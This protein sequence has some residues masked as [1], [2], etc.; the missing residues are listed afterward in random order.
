MNIIPIAPER[1]AELERFA[2][3]HGQSPAELLDDAIATYLAWQKRDYAEAIAGIRQGYE[4]V[5]AGRMMPA[6]QVFDDMRRKH[7]FPD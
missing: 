6:E 3:E 7:G 5:K 2:M 4:D 1:Q